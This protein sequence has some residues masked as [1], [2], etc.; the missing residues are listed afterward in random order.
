MVFETGP[1]LW[2]EHEIIVKV[3][4]LFL[5]LTMYP[6]KDLLG[7]SLK[8]VFS[9]L[10]MTYP[11]KDTEELPGSVD[12]FLFNR[13]LEVREVSILKR[14][15]SEFSGY[16][17][18]FFEKPASRIDR[19]FPLVHLM[20]SYA[21]KG[22]GIFTVT[23]DIILLDANQTFLNFFDAPGNQRE[24]SIGRPIHEI[25]KGWIGSNSEQVWRNIL[26]TGEPFQS[27]EYCYMGFE[28]S[29]TYWQTTMLPV[30][31][32]GQL[33]YVFEMTE[34]ITENVLKVKQNEEQAQVIKEQ[35][36]VL[37]ENL[38]MKDELISILS[39]EFKTPLAV[40]NSAIQAMETLCRDEITP[41]IQKYVKHIKQNVL[42]QLRLVNNFLDISRHNAGRLTLQPQNVDIVYLTRAIVDSIVLYAQQKQIRID[43]HSSRSRKIIAID[44]EK[45]GRILL[46]LLS[47]AIKY[48]P[49]GGQIDVRLAFRTRDKHQ[50]MTVRI[51]DNG[52]GIPKD[53]LNIIFDR[54]QRIENSLTSQAE[55]TGFGL[56]L[57]KL[58]VEMMHGRISVKSKE[59]VGTCFTLEL[60]V[61]EQSVLP[62]HQPQNE[63]SDRRLIQA[64]SIECS[65]IYEA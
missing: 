65:D 20:K 54:F 12:A 4:P 55:G 10:R 63:L 45:Y 8:E 52:V 62:A 61:A 56:T 37:E 40:I 43:F 42:R 7:K 32:L 33:K 47:N 15:V 22:I 46:N 18:G 38:R 44:D 21:L 2:V 29:P 31:E 5:Q 50:I 35:K 11:F 30:F 23:P 39:H 53:K 27:G 3:N 64:A 19:K 17:L 34:D 24:Y 13:S 26:A 49:N 14:R 16:V 51:I 58:L 57:V 25:V 9:L 36:R 60:P 48:S 41:S 28:R 6:E 59:D 1:Y